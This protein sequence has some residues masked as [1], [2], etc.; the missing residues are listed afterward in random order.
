MK[1]KAFKNHITQGDALEVLRQIPAESVDMA[2]AD[3]PFNLN[4]KYSNYKD[5][6]NT[7][8]YLEWCYK[9]LDEMVR[10]VKPTGSILVHNVPR[11]LTYYLKGARN[12]HPTAD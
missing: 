1:I 8:D 2:F 4:K 11:W 10:I 6:R 12:P 7:I 3:P 9:W 5:D